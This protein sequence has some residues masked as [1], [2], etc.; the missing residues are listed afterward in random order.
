MAEGAR[1]RDRSIS[2]CV[3]G[4]GDQG[5]GHIGQRQFD[6]VRL[7]HQIEPVRDLRARRHR[8]SADQFIPFEVAGRDRRCEQIGLTPLRMTHDGQACAD[9]RLHHPSGAQ[10]VERVPAV[11]DAL[12]E[13]MESAGAQPL[14]VCRDDGMARRDDL[15]Q[16][17]LYDLDIAVLRPVRVVA[18][19]SADSGKPGG[20]MGPDNDRPSAL[21]GRSG[22]NRDGA[23]HR[24]RLPC[25]IARKVHDEVVPRRARQCHRPV[26][27][28]LA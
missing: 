28:P 19:R 26:K 1:M 2:G 7:A 13:R 8:D 3:V 6:L 16:Q 18:R 27:R 12:Q 10:H 5:V 4:I 22:R 21:R 15:V 24:D 25:R 9:V 11:R 17:T 23:G 20:A 14:V